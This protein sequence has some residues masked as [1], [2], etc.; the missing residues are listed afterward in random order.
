MT[1]NPNNIAAYLDS[2]SDDLMMLSESIPSLTELVEKKDQ[3]LEEAQEKGCEID[4]DTGLLPEK[5]QEILITHVW[6]LL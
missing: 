1:I 4:P 5:I 2:I 6:K 3:A